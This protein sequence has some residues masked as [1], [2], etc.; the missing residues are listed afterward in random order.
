MARTLL[1]ILAAVTLAAAVAL[2]TALPAFAAQSGP[3]VDPTV[4][5]RVERLSARS[6]RYQALLHVANVVW[7]SH[8]T[9][10]RRIDAEIH[11][12]AQRQVR[13]FARAVATD[14]R[15][16]HGLPKSLPA[17]SLTITTRV[18]LVDASVLSLVTEEEAYFRGAASPAQS[19]HGLTFDLRTGAA[20]TLASLFRARAAYLPALARLSTAALRRF[21]PAGAHC[22]IGGAPAAKATAY[23]SWWLDGTGLVLGF[24][25]GLYTAAYCGPPALTLPAT[26]L[27]RLAAPLGPLGG[28]AR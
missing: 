9:V 4:R 2:G 27:R 10:A 18:S 15:H 6:P 20:Y 17:S 3:A 23:A 1:R 7:P 11:A 5:I 14:L 19:T 21:R 24:P 16:A 12:W 26:A 25:A 8:G 13:R 28:F 22:Y